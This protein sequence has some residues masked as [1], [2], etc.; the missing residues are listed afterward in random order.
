MAP[1]LISLA[2]GLSVTGRLDRPDIEGLAQAGV[3]TIVNNRPD[4][5]DPGQL[6]AAEARRFAEALG[7]RL[8]PH[9]DH[10]RDVVARRCRRV[11][12]NLARCA[13]AGRSPLPQRNAL[14]PPVGTEPNARGRRP[15]C[16][17]R[18]SRSSRNRHR[19][20]S[21]DSRAAALAPASLAPNSRCFWTFSPASCDNAAPHLLYGRCRGPES[22]YADDQ[23]HPH[24][25]SRLFR[26]QRA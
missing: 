17:G 11:R 25:F 3:R 18:R 4:G 2:P 26:A 1:Q 16:P 21:R 12:C 7:D 5:E 22:V 6:P 10:G 14:D 15:A 13:G 8:S 19:Q 23:R 9:S 20:P 24:R